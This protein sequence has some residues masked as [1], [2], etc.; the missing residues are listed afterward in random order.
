MIKS[1]NV[2]GLSEN[3]LLA[4]EKLGYLT[5][6]PVQEQ[7]IP[8]VL[9]AR[10]VCAAA[11]TGTGKTAA[12]TLP[13]MDLLSKRKA[14]PVVAKQKRKGPFVL[15]ITPTR[16]LAQQIDATARIVG[17]YVDLTVL[18]VVGGT[19]YGPQISKLNTGVDILVATPG[20]LIDL[21]E[22][23]AVSLKDVEFLIL[24][25]ADRMLDMGF[26]PSV[27]KIVAQVPKKR[28]TLLFS[29]TLDKTIMTQASSFVTDPVFVEIEHRDVTADT[30]EEYIMPVDRS[31]KPPLLTALAEQMGRARIIVFT[32]TKHGADNCMKRLVKAGFYAGAIHAD[33][34]Q[35]QRERALKDFREGQLDILVATDVIARGIDIDQVDYVI[36]Y[37]VPATPEDYVHRVGR[38]GRAGQTGVAITFVG[39][40]EISTLRDIEFFKK[41]IIETFDLEG[42]TYVDSR[43]I[44]SPERSAE[45]IVQSRNRSRQGSSPQRPKPT[46]TTLKPKNDPLATTRSV[47]ARRHSPQEL[48]EMA[49]KR[50]EQKNLPSKRKSGKPGAG[51]RNS[52]ESDTSSRNKREPVGKSAPASRTPVRP[53]KS[54][55]AAE[56]LTTY[57]NEVS[58]PQAKKKPRPGQHSSGLRR[59]F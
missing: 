20:R 57:K 4:V 34:S 44:P 3:I 49:A 12:F 9:E 29:A 40:D 8:L 1:F 46:D 28:Q 41:Q 32:R 26:W 48:E 7:T 22:R 2:L 52:S 42:F 15:I 35:S 21:M 50:T 17:S 14:D 6:T 23:N 47:P 54:K 16:E 24:D 18:T 37:D 55:A 39:P 31:Q 58:S 13:V 43:I 38:T 10:D 5:A 45:R 36:N 30:V 33:R 11:Q 53:K 25:E 27:R 56:A 51:R 59:G 19:Q